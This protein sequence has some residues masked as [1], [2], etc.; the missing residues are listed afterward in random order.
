MT[1][2]LIYAFIS[3]LITILTP[4]IWPILPVVLSSGSNSDGFQK[5]S[6]MI[7]GIITSFTVLTVGLSTLVRLFNF[8]PNILRNSALIFI[9]LIGLTMVIPSISIAIESFISRLTG[10]F[11][12]I[13]HHRKN[14][15]LSGLFTGLSL[16]ILWTPC[17]GPILATVASLTVTGLITP[18]IFWVTLF[19]ALGASIPLITIAYGGQKILSESKK[20]SP[21]VG[22]IQQ[23]FGVIIIVTAFALYLHLDTYSQLYLEKVLPSFSSTFYQIEQT[24]VIRR[25]LELLKKNKSKI[26][27]AITNNMLLN[28]NQKAPNFSGATNWINTSQPLDIIGLRGKVILVDFWTY[29]CIN[30]IRTLP[31]VSGWYDKYKNSGFTVI[32]IH[33]PEFEFEKNPSN[34]EAATKQFRISYPIA[35]DNNY[36]IWNN[37]NN[38]YW[39]AEYLIDAK[40]YIRRTHF[41]EGEYDQ[42]EKAIQLL[43]NDNGQ[44]APQSL[45]NINDQPP[46]IQLSPETYVGLKRMEY[47]YP[48]GGISPG[49]NNYTLP[50]TIPENTFSFGGTWN[51]NDESADSIKNSTLIYN[52]QANQVYLVMRPHTPKTTG[53]AK[54]FLDGKP[55]ESKNAGDDVHNS[56]V[57]INGDR[58]YSLIKLSNNSSVNH[59]LRID[60]SDSN[61]DVFAFTFG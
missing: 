28:T 26:Q 11:G 32:G 46:K 14:N 44:S 15:F 27:T 49:A 9:A 55:I 30:C 25:Q 4:C 59:I 31:Y 16:G 33:T 3:G 50:D 5:P 40:G 24:P 7:I 60:F 8:D 52:F 37:Y 29:T 17:A 13:N 38:S 41:G 58:L 61:I 2:L 10:L 39:P 1:I 23:G 45:I 35:Q 43:I 20:I 12:Q 57:E 51:I 53:S 42:M 22:A 36:T 34:V 47:F 18:E 54:I 19:Y 48:S 21:Y 6:G 56:I